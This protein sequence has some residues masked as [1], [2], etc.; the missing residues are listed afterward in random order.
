[1]ASDRVGDIYS[2]TLAVFEQQSDPHEPLTTPEVAAALDAQRRTI[3]QRLSQLVK[4]GDLKTKEVGAN[5]RVWWRSD[6]SSRHTEAGSVPTTQLA[7]SNH[8]SRDLAPADTPEETTDGVWDGNANRWA[9][10]LH[11]MIDGVAVL[12]SNGQYQYTNSAHADIYGYEDP[13]AFLGEHWAM[14]YDGDELERFEQEIIPAVNERGGWR[15]EAIGKRKDGTTFAQELSLAA[16]D[17]D[18]LVCVVR[19]IT[20]RKERK[21]QLRD[22]REFNEELVEQVPFGMFR[23]DENLR[24]TYENPRAEE[25]I[26]LPDDEESS[27]AMGV[28][29]NELPPIVETG[30]SAL[31]ETLPDGET[32]E[33]DFPFESIYGKEAYFTGR[34]VPVYRDGEFDGAILMATDISERRQ[35][36]RQLE[37]Q[38]E[39]LEA[40]DELHNAVRGITDA[41]IDQPTR[42]AIEQAVCDR[43]AESDS[44]RLAW[45]GVADSEHRVDVRAVAGTDDHLNEAPTTTG[46]DV[47]P[48][49]RLIERAVTTQTM[50]VLQDARTD[51][52][53]ERLG[54]HARELRYQSVAVI[55]ISHQGVIHGILGVCSERADAFADAEQEVIGQLGDVVG[56]AIAAVDRKRALMSD[57]VV[58]LELQIPTS[59]DDF[60]IPPTDSTITIDRITP[61][62][63]EEFLLYGWA[64]VD[65]VSVLEQFRQQRL[66]WGAVET[67]DERESEVRF[68]QRLSSEPIVSTIAAHG[69]NFT[70]GA[71]E[72]G[73]IS[74]TVEL[75]PGTDTR[76]IVETIQRTYPSA[77]VVRQRQMTREAATSGDLLQLLAENLTN[78]QRAAVEAAYFGGISTPLD[79]G[80]VPISRTRSRSRH[81]RSTNISEKQSGNCSRSCL[82]NSD[83]GGTNLSG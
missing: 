29:I 61:L 51:P 47:L 78:R 48:D 15:G 68:Q 31:F 35:Y 33:F 17:D 50:Q 65:A 9:R 18:G 64:A 66:E 58:E 54:E 53:S 14:C 52:S 59:G 27:D 75:L 49:S 42:T 80:P 30:Q 46:P 21:R 25:I 4:R 38:R 2:E 39:Q 63:D 16:T 41:V 40:L 7:V 81:R 45:I 60:S 6:D 3:Y 22:A 12:D 13:T 79:L 44:Y 5:A 24:I 74:V 37:R 62:G 23:L 70:R 10:V 19:D 43:L 83:M 11:S 57:E 73:T 71:I 34:A 1:M 55:P 20:N 82:L 67:F 77:Q 56:H 32:I 72:N 36:E 76:A 28:P 8:S 26:G 69:G